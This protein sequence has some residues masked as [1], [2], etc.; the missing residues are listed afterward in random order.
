MQIYLDNAATTP[1]DRCVAKTIFD[2]QQSTF[3]NPSSPHRHGQQS[4]IKLEEVRDFIASNLNCLSKEIIFTSGGTES[5]NKALIG[6]C[7]ANKEKGNHVVVSAIEH[8]S[9]LD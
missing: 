6:G 8:P 2:W 3:G 7:L 1:V 4:K 9:V 5:N